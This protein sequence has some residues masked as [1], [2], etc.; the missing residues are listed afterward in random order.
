MED[1]EAKIESTLRNEKFPPELLGRVDAI[2]PFQPLSIETKRRIIQNKLDKLVIDVRDKHGVS[3]F[4]S[5]KVLQYLAEDV[6]KTNTDSGGARESVRMLNNEVTSAVATFL[7]AYPEV[8]RVGVGVSGEM[9]SENKKRRK[10]GAEIQVGR[11][12]G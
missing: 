5:K 8:Q 4:I 7:N 9:R 10:S 12:T 6:V 2:V 3:L 11:Y 1:F